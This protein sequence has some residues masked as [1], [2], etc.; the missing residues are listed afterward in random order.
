MR[1]LLEVF[2][3]PHGS[4]SSRSGFR[5]PADIKSTLSR[6]NSRCQ[7]ECIA[8]GACPGLLVVTT[9]ILFTI[10]TCFQCNSLSSILCPGGV[11]EYARLNVS[12]T[13]LSRPNARL[14]QTLIPW[15]VTLVAHAP[16]SAKSKCNVRSGGEVRSPGQIQ[17]DTLRQGESRPLNY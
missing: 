5:D 3:P 6:T 12:K 14:S 9:Y 17:N 1:R 4:R 10:P 8:G 16:D 11:H 15:N 2:G 13:P 7:R